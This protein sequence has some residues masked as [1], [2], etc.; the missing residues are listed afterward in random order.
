MYLCSSEQ[1]YSYRYGSHAHYKYYCTSRGSK[2]SFAINAAQESPV[3]ILFSFPKNISSEIVLKHFD[4][5]DLTHLQRQYPLLS[6]RIRNALALFQI[7]PTSVLSNPPISSFF[8]DRKINT[9][10]LYTDAKKKVTREESLQLFYKFHE[11]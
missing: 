3:A 2:Y 9:S 11:K 6:Y 10:L 7:T 4:E 5:R 8:L 1:S